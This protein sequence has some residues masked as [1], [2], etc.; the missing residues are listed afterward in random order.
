MSHAH[1]LESKEELFRQ[2][3]VASLRKRALLLSGPFVVCALVA[4]HLVLFWDRVADQSLFQPQVALR[5]LLT[6]VFV[7]VAWRFRGAGVPILRGR[8]ALVFWLMVALLHASFVGPLAEE[9]LGTSAEGGELSLLL[10]VPGILVAGVGL[11]L[12]SAGTRDETVPSVAKTVVHRRSAG[13][14]SRF[15]VEAGFLPSLSRRPP[16]A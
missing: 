10:V 5:W 9:G 4:Y 13:P 14:V 11:F 6:L 7:W 15:V 8:K 2:I 1:Q 16:P 3:R 12:L